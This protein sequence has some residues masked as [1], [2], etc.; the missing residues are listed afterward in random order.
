VLAYWRELGWTVH[1][2][3]QAVYAHSPDGHHHLIVGCWGKR[4]P[5]PAWADRLGHVSEGYDRR[6]E[7][8]RDEQAWRRLAR[9]DR[10]RFLGLMQWWRWPQPVVYRWDGQP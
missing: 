4:E 9:D 6:Q 2:V 3:G 5:R 1:T 7:R 8:C 10:G